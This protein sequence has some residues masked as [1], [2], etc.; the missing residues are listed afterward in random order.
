MCGNTNS[1]DN[2][3]EQVRDRPLARASV[4]ELT[5]EEQVRE[6]MHQRPG[7]DEICQEVSLERFVGKAGNKPDRR[8]KL[9]EGCSTRSTQNRVIVVQPMPIEGEPKAFRVVPR[10]SYIAPPDRPQPLGWILDPRPGL[11]HG[12]RQRFEAERR[13]C[14]EEP[15]HVTEVMRWCSV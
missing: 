13:Q 8:L 14:R 4:V 10:E 3:L 12:R 9:P 5:G 15:C 11:S 7:M 2:A 6:A 1:P